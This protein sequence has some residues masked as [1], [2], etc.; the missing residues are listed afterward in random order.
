MNKTTSKDFHRTT[1][2]SV[3]YCNQSPRIITTATPI[4]HHRYHNKSSIAVHTCYSSAI[5]PSQALPCDPHTAIRPKMQSWSSYTQLPLERYSPT[6][7]PHRALSSQAPDVSSWNTGSASYVTEADHAVS[8]DFSYSMVRSPASD[9]TAKSLRMSIS[10]LIAVEN[11]LRPFSAP[12]SIK[13]DLPSL[14]DSD[15]MHVDA[16]QPESAF[17]LSEIP[18]ARPSTAAFQDATVVQNSEKQPQY[19]QASQPMVVDLNER[20]YTETLI[21]YQEIPAR[22]WRAIDRLAD[23]VMVS[24]CISY[25]RREGR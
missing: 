15:I 14:N 13:V 10:E 3:S 9:G 23:L 16:H 17:D 8:Q 19:Y 22:E 18:G 21:G 12:A 1:C 20:E 7:L 24:C 4:S 5:S 25:S 6:T 11:T 2:I